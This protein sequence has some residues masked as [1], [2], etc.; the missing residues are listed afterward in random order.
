MRTFA[1]G[2][3]CSVCAELPNPR[4]SRPVKQTVYTVGEIAE[5][6]GISRFRTLM[7]LKTNGITPKRSGTKF[8]VTLYQL[9]NGFPELW[10]SIK[11]RAE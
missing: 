3:A 11:E 5:L 7:L 4:L 10:Y 1:V 6:A 9:R 8:I 2:S